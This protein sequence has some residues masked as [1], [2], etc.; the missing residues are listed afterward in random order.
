ME[1]WKP[2]RRWSGVYEVS[3]LGNV[4]RGARVLSFGVLSNGYRQARASLNGNRTLK[5]A[6]VHRLVAEEF[7]GELPDHM[8]VNHKNGDRAD[9][10]VEN[11]EI[12]TA[13]ENARHAYHVLGRSK[14]AGSKHPAA[15]LT[16]EIVCEIRWLFGLGV[17]QVDLAREYLMDKTTIRDIVHRYRWKHI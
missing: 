15:K 9:N 7:I 2:I 14:P 4:R 17:K 8:Q 11:L 13:S 10:R 1:V 6:L 16:E 12:V 3:S 5:S